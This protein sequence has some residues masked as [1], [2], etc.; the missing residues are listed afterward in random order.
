M[1]STRVTKPHVLLVED[2]EPLRNFLKEELEKRYPGWRVQP[3]P[4]KT[5]GLRILNEQLASKAPIALVLTDLHLAPGKDTSGMDMLREARG[6]DPLVTVILYTDHDELLQRYAALEGGAFDVIE[7]SLRKGNDFFEEV[8]VKALAALRFRELED[9]VH[10][11]RRYFDPRL[12]EMIE[13]DPSL[14]D[15]KKRTVTICFWDIQGFSL[16]TE[17]LKT[18][19]ELVSGFLRDYYDSVSGI[20]FQHQGVVD[21]FIGDGVMALFGV[22]SPDEQPGPSA[23]A[24][25]QAA[26]AVRIA[27]D[28]A[29]ARWKPKWVFGSGGRTPVIGLRCGVHTGEALVGNAG[30]DFRDQFTALGES[31]NLASRFE[32]EADGAKRQ[33][34]ISQT[35]QSLVNP[36]IRTAW[37]KQIPR[38]KNIEG[39]FDLYDVEG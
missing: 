33:I 25:V 38:V 23:V 30:T 37:V 8:S 19:P 31:V 4:N 10:F 20:I 28:Q 14:L 5:E 9:R 7:K 11:L 12:F 26:K 6:I 27:F 35:T 2:E 1:P 36:P 32:Q 18:A 17:Q 3:A 22:F 15:L 16:L 29:V 13:K 39:P 24:S 21:K 34:L